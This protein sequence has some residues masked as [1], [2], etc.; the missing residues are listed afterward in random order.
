MKKILSILMLSSL[1]LGLYAQSE[2]E[3]L[4]TKKGVPIVPAVGDFAIGIDATPF[5]RYVGNL[6]SGNNPYFPSFG[7]TAQEP[8]SIFM[9][10]KASNSL[11]YRSALLIGFSNETSKSENPVDNDQLDKYS[12]SALSIGL[13]GGI[14]KHRDFFGR[15]SGYFGAEVGVRNNPY[16]TSGYYGSISFKD[17]NNSDNDYKETG[18]NTLSVC[19]GGLAGVEFYF[20][21]R[22]AL[23]GEFGYY[24]SYYTQ[25]KRVYKPASGDENVVNYGSGGFEFMPYPSG[26]LI[27]LFYF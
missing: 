9:K 2:T 14:E 24:L 3:V 1:I 6:F 7:F 12:S 19:A 8:G 16:Y 25:L 22:I 13:T 17:G 10:Y 18:G 4:T 23:M 5:F 15:L 27:L 20:A 11:T 26:N 21:P